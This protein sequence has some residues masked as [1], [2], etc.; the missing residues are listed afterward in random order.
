MLTF[1]PDGHVRTGS[2]TLAEIIANDEYFDETENNEKEFEEDEEE[3]EPKKFKMMGFELDMTY[4]RTLK[5]FIRILQ[6][7]SIKRHL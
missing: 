7:V 3:K 2:R 4:P 6:I 1:N 5:G